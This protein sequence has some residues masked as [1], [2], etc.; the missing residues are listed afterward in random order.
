MYIHDSVIPYGKEGL[1]IIPTLQSPIDIET[2]VIDI[3]PFS[4]PGL[5]ELNV[6]HYSIGHEGC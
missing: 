5:F 4:T 1:S 3:F 2:I 6:H